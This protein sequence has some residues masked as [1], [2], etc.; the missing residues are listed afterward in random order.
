MPT[1]LFLY[2]EQGEMPQQANPQGETPDDASPDRQQP[3]AGGETPSWDEW[4][5]AQDE[6]VRG[7][8]AAHTSGLKNALESER[9]QRKELAR[10]LKEA[11]G[12]LEAGSEART[13]LEKMQTDLEIQQRRA[14]FYEAAS[15]GGVRNLKL[16]W[17]V[18]QAEDLFDRQGRPDLTRLKEA[19]PELFGVAKA[20]AGN[21]G[22]G[23]GTQPQTQSMN[24]FIRAAAGRQ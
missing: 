2:K 6:G 21:A 9:S 15:A 12:K 13:A 22:A 3:P 20:P 11:S 7:L 16:A 1:A 8:A 18:A 10:Q 24:D 4:L 19:A 5:A 23:G 14:D 17:L